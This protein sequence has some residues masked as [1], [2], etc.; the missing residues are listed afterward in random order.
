MMFS[1]SKGS[2]R[3]LR[4]AFSENQADQ[5]NPPSNS[6][7]LVSLVRWALCSLCV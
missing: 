7:D 6:S 3:L 2:V 5:W 4:A 1:R